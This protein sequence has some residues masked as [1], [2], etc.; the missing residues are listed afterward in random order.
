MRGD[1]DPLR[2]RA[3]AERPPADAALRS[4]AA[5]R[6]V[7]AMSEAALRG[8]SVA[9]M[10]LVDHA[11]CLLRA[12]NKMA[13]LA[14]GILR[15]PAWD[16]MLCLFINCEEGGILFVKQLILSCG[17]SPTAALR[18]IDRLEDAHFIERLSDPLDRRRVIVRLS[19]SGRTAMFA[20]LE[21]AFQATPRSENPQ[22]GDA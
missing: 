19:E 9:Q 11:R 13:R 6:A 10:E 1:R 4:P 16:M 18:H 21:D 3:E 22:R 15:D 12:R 7:T 5:S 14:P 2:R 17:E 20:M 8:G